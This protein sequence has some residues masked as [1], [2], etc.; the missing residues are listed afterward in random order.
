MQPSLTA[1]ESEAEQLFLEASRGRI[2]KLEA[3]IL[4]RDLER[5]SPLAGSY[6]RWLLVRF[7]PLLLAWG[8]ALNR[9][10]SSEA[11]LRLI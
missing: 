10:S 3:R 5:R 1:E 2:T 8:S 9:L 4:A 7:R 6:L 11:H